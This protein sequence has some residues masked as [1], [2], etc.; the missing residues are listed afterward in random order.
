MTYEELLLENKQLKEE[1][2]TFL[3]YLQ[4]AIQ[5]MDIVCNNQNGFLRVSNPV[6]HEISYE[7]DIFNTLTPEEKKLVKKLNLNTKITT[8]NYTCGTYEWRF[9]NDIEKLLRGSE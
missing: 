6:R 9:R 4:L 1:R 2:T 8:H 5:D 3:K 7:S